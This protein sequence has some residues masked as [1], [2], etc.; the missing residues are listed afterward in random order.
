MKSIKLGLAIIF[1][2]LLNVETGYACSCIAPPPVTQALDQAG[3]VFSG[4]VL[5]VKRVRNNRQGELGNVEVVFAVNTSWKGAERRVVSVFTASQSAA[6][7]YGFRKG[8]TYLVYA[9]G[10]AQGKLTTSICSRTKRLKDARDDLGELGA[11]KSM[12]RT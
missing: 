9:N 12:R 4:K 5:Q 11:G 8:M 1:F 10:D 3:A 7:G 2:L 6:C